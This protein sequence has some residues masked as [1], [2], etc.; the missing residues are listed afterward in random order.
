MQSGNSS[1]LKD[2]WEIDPGAVAAFAG[3]HPPLARA[4]DAVGAPHIRKRTGGFQGVF[5]IIVEQQVSVAS[6]DAIWGRCRKQLRVASA[7]AILA[8]EDA[9]LAACGLSGPK[10]RYVKAAAAAFVEGE[11]TPAKLRKLDDDAAMERLVAIK[12]VGPWT[13]AIYLMFCEGRVNLWP[14][15]DVA[16]QTAYQHAA[17]LSER[18][19]AKALDADA[20]KWRPY[21]SLAAHILWTYFAHLKGRKPVD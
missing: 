13:A 21:R 3:D 7:K 8:T 4:L 9:A 16:L 19:N 11:V 20:E 10:I 15:G 14:P 5:R 18:P 2:I 6:A 17:Q 1:S 12:G